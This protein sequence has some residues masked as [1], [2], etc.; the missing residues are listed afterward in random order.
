MRR[1]AL[2][3]LFALVSAVRA[4]PELNADGLLDPDKA[5]QFSARALDAST[6]EVRYV[7]ADGYYLYRDRFRFAAQPA[8]VSL[9][10]PQFPKGVVHEDQFFGKQE[11]YRKEVRIRLPVDAGGAGSVKL[12]VTSQGCADSGVCYVPYDQS[13]ELRFA[14]TSGAP[15]SFSE[16][17]K[18]EAPLSRAAAEPAPSPNDEA[19]F[20]QM[21]E[22]GRIWAT[23]A[24]FFGAGLLLTFTPCVLPMVPILS[25]IIVGE[26]HG[27]TRGR[28]L[29]LSIA[30]VS[31]MAVTYTA[32]GVGAALS[33]NLLSA[34]L[35]NAW[36]LSAFALVFVA[37]ALSMFGLYDLSLPSAIHG[38]LH[39]AHSRLRGGQFGAVA[40]MG[41]LSAAIV[42]PCVA[43]PLAGA[44]L[45]I[46]QTRDTVLGGSALFA[47][48]LGM[49][50]PLIAVGVSEGAFLPKSGHWMRTVKRFFGALLLGVAIWTVAPVIPVAAQ[51]LLWGALL[52]GVGVF[53]HA[54]DPLPANAHG[55]VRLGKAVGILALL[56]GVAQLAGAFSGA[57]DPL[58]PL[59]TLLGSQPASASAP[60]FER[61]K[62]LAELESR[63]RGA[64]RPVMLDFYAD[65]CVSCKEMERF[66]F[67]DP[68]VQARLAQMLV[69]QADVTGNDAD[70]KALLKRFRLFGPP[71]IVFFDREGREI[72][73]LRV[74]GYQPPEKFAATL[75]AASAGRR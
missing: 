56:A 73:G 38:R 26:G 34:A 45:Y 19:R 70:D 16:L 51:M 20:T 62:T 71:G 23:L 37:L 47:M 11:T 42:S 39:D 48:A 24:A 52:V 69:L 29:W 4:A 32:I 44:L 25:G 9:G 13:A 30:Y 31:G 57:R 5:F 66:T 61:V 12:T 36:V 22:S 18:D 59:S 67:G 50:V 10:A 64:G 28:A 21:L 74:I 3:L 41:I 8:S 6:L 46:S 49:G 17:L 53:L 68:A 75:D 60:R 27:V 58:Q 72:E 2:L 54:V 43:A 15:R 7:I 65:W 63:V 1:L 40:L 55:L 14:S 35:Q 33:G